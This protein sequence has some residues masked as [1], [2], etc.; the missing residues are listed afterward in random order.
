MNRLRRTGLDGAFESVQCFG[1]APPVGTAVEINPRTKEEKA[2]REVGAGQKHGDH[3]ERAALLLPAHLTLVERIRENSRN[4]TISF[5]T[6][7]S[8]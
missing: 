1:C 6:K 2:R 8:S 4:V 7:I 3:G 5:T